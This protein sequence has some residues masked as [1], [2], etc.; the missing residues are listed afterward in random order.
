VADYGLIDSYLEDLAAA[1][2]WHRDADDIVDET[3]D[4]LCCAVE[5]RIGDGVDPEAAQRE[6]LEGFGD[7]AMVA[8]AF[9]TTR[10][11][12]LALP[13]RSTRDAGVLAYAT[14]GLW[15]AVPVV[16]HLGGWFYDRLDD[17]RSAPDEV[18]SNAQLLVIGVM[19][20]TL[21]GAAATLLATMLI[22]RERHGG[23]GLLGMV[24]IAAI[25]LG[26]LA[27]WFGWFFI[28]WGS[29]L[30]AGTALV[31]VDLWRRGIA[32][33]RAILTTGTGLAIGGVTWAVLRLSEVGGPDQHG[34]YLVANAAGLVIGSIILAT[35][36]L[37][38]GRWLANEEPV[39]FPD[40]TY[41][42]PA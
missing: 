14:A 2:R 1:L 17:G 10:S 11:G 3:D 9:A 32:P 29:L 19:A 23:F 35:G 30:I 6:V 5:R 33:K 34:D 4:H 40:P 20:M 26:C 8:R 39:E 21:L 36:L 27:S 13:T 16:W 25:A 31:A 37:G 22:L 15:L 42:A 7:P 28:G 18:G 12:R 41:L 38:I 24:G